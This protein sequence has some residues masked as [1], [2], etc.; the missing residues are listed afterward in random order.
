MRVLNPKEWAEAKVR[1]LVSS[2]DGRRSWQTIGVS[3]NIMDASWQALV[4][5]MEYALMECE[6]K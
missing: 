6:K 2:S 5:S 1:V 3:E 4:E